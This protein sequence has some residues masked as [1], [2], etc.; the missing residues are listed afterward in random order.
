MDDGNLYYN[1]N[2]CH[3]TLSV[4]GF[5]DESRNNII[6]Y[7]KVSYGINFKKIGKAIRVTSVKETKI[8]MGVVEKFIPKCMKRKTLSF[9]YKR[10]DK[11][12]TNEQKK[13]RN[14]KYQ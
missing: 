1:G 7:F 13:Y 4:D 14:K 6:K 12:L 5:N 10:Y 3:L 8:F 9:Q 11:T 2:N